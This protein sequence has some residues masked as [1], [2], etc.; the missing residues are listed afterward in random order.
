MSSQEA[1]PSSAEDRLVPVPIIVAGPDGKPTTTYAL[2]SASLLSQPNL[3][4]SSLLPQ[5]PPMPAG[6]T[7]LPS[8]G[9]NAQAT[10]QP[11]SSDA[12]GAGSL[13]GFNDFVP[14]SPMP[15]MYPNL[16]TQS[17]IAPASA[18]NAARSGM[19]EPSASYAPIP[20][21][22]L[23]KKNMVNTNNFQPP[24]T[25]APALH[26]QPLAASPKTFDF[27]SGLTPPSPLSFSHL[28]QQNSP[29]TAAAE[30]Q[31]FPPESFG[32]STSSQASGQS[33]SSP[34][35]SAPSVEND[36]DD[37]RRRN[38]AASARFRAKKKLREQAMERMSREMTVKVDILER[39]LYDM[40]QEILWL[41]KLLA[42]RDGPE[43][44]SQLY[45]TNFKNPGQQPLLRKTL[46]PYPTP[47]QPV[48][49][50]EP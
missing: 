3:S 50:I 5:I 22:P 44:L 9:A 47:S 37:K 13:Q 38:T 49:K 28:L 48:A 6:P 8:K 36:D 26:I 40:D 35:P 43:T 39:K 10:P 27:S 46:Q 18:G 29:T 15:S 12:L 11:A 31:S 23:Q 1:L 20:S 17:P 21:Q 4:L 2:V 34:P 32:S 24:Q 30:N 7:I 42:E 45:A 41:R 14:Q 33:S 19:R 25:K 16:S